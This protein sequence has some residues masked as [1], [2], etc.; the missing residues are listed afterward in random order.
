MSDYNIIGAQ[1][2]EIDRLRAELA[3]WK[4]AHIEL[5][6][7]YDRQRAGLQWYAEMFCEGWC[8]ESHSTAAFDDCS[9]CK[10]RAILAKTAKERE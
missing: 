6:E 9:G 7:M 8:K 5:G 3:T 4:K 10:A 1:E 2:A